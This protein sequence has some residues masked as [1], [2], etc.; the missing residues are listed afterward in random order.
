MD[1]FEQIE[2]VIARNVDKSLNRVGLNVDCATF[3]KLVRLNFNAFCE[4]A[5]GDS[6]L[7]V[8]DAVNFPV[9]VRLVD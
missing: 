4:F 3:S 8:L 7:P 1:R 6:K 2:N 9:D 5:D